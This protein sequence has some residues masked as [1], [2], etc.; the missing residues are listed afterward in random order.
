MDKR[1]TFVV[2]KCS[3]NVSSV[4]RDDCAT[5]QKTS[6]LKSSQHIVEACK[7]S[8]RFPTKTEAS[9]VLGAVQRRADFALGIGFFL[10]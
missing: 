8:Q 1:P 9:D 7:L 3:S 6:T 10:R 2:S 5:F 4:N